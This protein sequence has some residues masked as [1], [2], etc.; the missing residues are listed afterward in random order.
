MSHCACGSGQTFELC[1]ARFITDGKKAIT[2]EELMRAR[3]TAHTQA[4]MAFILKTHHPSTR[5]DI[6]EASTAKWAS[7]S[8]W[9]GLEIR[10]VEGGQEPDRQARVEF[11]AKYRDGAGRRHDHAEIA[12]FE[13]HNNEWFFKDAE[14]PKVTQFKR[15]AP[16][17]GRNDPCA[18]GSGKKYK[19][20]CA[21][22]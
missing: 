18:C 5:S 8:D 16:K 21:A 19:K 12:L 14:M 6:D 13:K 10:D 15:E 11:I 9:L 2:A 20:C 3:Y 1:C 22:T 17:Q 7:E 4:N